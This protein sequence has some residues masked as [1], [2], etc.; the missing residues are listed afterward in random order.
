MAIPLKEKIRGVVYAYSPL[1]R[2]DLVKD[3]GT[4]WIRLNVPFPW[5]GEIGGAL[6][7]RWVKYGCAST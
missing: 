5:E 6:S 1:E 4:D 2:W 3:L 7:S